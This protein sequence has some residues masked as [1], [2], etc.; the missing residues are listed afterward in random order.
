MPSPARTPSQQALELAGDI[1][2]FDAEG[3]SRPFRSLYEGPRAIGE[4]Q[5]VI[6]VRHFF[7]GVG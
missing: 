5:L 4:Q 1:S 7:C 3:N 2:I 6:F